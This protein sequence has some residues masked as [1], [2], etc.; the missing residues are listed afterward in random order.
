[1]SAIPGLVYREDYFSDPAGWSAVKDLL[2]DIFGIDISPLDRLGGPDPTSMPSAWF[3]ENGRCIANLSAF[4][5]PVVMNGRPV[6]AAGLQSGAV[7]PEWRGRGLFRSVLT[8]TLERIDDAGFAAALLYTDKPTLYEP[9]GFV[10]VQQFFF[11]GTPPA[12][13]TQQAGTRRLDVNDA[14]DLDILRGLLARRSPV[15][16]RFAVSA[17]SAMFLLNCVLVD[18]V[19]LD[20]LTDYECVVAWRMGAGEVF[21]LLDI[22]G[23]EMPSLATI[24][25][26]LSIA[27]AKVIVHVP[28]DRLG[29]MGTSVRGETDLVFM[30]RGA[31]GRVPT[32]PFCLSPMA[33]F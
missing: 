21:E 10:A 14:G 4:S 24:L 31:T 17:Q 16:Y 28:P 2:R 23:P 26:L 11:E 19:R 5:M 15:S 30:I 33:E 18:A 9:Y 32:E 25:A 29:W 13:G 3:D 27:P 1:M 12:S 6:R 22:V 8:R 7:R 20:V